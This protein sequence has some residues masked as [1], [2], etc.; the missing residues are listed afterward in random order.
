MSI[1]NKSLRYA[2][3]NPGKVGIGM[4]GIALAGGIIGAASNDNSAVAG[5]FSGGNLAGGAASLAAAG[6]MSTKRGMGAL[7]RMGLNKKGAQ[8][9]IGA[10]AVTGALGIG[11]GAAQSGMDGW[12]AFGTQMAYGV[13]AGVGLYMADSK[14]KRSAMTKPLNRVRSAFKGIKR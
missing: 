3:R 8:F 14:M 6:I 7:G 11:V 5:Y 1:F 4:A 10:G 12:G 9:M 2:S 13:A